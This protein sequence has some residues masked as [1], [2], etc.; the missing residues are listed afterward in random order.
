MF[1]SE[2]IQ[3][4]LENKYDIVLS[5]SSNIKILKDMGYSFSAPILS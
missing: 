4:E 1:N 2:D 5:T 3:K